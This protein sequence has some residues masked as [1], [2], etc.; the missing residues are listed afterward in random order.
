[1]EGIFRRRSSQIT[2]RFSFGATVDARV[3]SFIL[4]FNIDHLLQIQEFVSSTN[5]ATAAAVGKEASKKPTVAYNVGVLC[6]RPAK[7]R[8]LIFQTK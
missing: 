1:M 7:I 8:S 3:S 2:E 5:V 6:V 4:I